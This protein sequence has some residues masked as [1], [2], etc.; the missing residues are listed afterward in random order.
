[1]NVMITGAGGLI[2]RKLVPMLEQAGHHVV[3]LTRGK[4]L[5]PEMRVW[6]PQATKLSPAVLDGCEAIIHL[7]GENIGEGRW[8]PQKKERIRSS[9]VHGTRLLAEAIAGMNNP[10]GAFICASATGFYGNRGDEILTEASRAGTG[11]LAEV[12]QEWEAAAD[13]ARNITRVVHIRT[14]VVLSTAGGALAKMLLPF[15]LGVGGVIGDGHQF[16]SWISIE[17]SARLFQ[18]A[19]ERNDLSGPINGTAPQPVTNR[20]FTKTFG[21]VLSR[22]TIFPMPAFAARLVLGE[23]ADALLLASTRTI[24]ETALNNGF[25][26]QHPTLEAALRAQLTST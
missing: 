8:T 14:G 12:C 15:K 17:D 26:F 24:P 6:D 13:P 10:P 23:M 7:A 20:E 4:S 5:G 2:G 16:W 9:R 25:E 11:F 22:P 1:M 18:F 3:I 21:R 19:L